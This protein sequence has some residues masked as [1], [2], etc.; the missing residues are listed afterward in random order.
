MPRVSTKLYPLTSSLSEK[1]NCSQKGVL[2]PYLPYGLKVETNFYI[3]A[4]EIIGYYK[5]NIYCML[6]GNVDLLSI[7]DH[8]IKPML[9]PLSDFP[10][11]LWYNEDDEEYEIY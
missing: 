2:A 5:Q 4:A 9:R 8:A 10:T 11:Q 6:N 7:E 1:S 3:E